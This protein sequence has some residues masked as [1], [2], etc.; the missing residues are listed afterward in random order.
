M[1][2]VVVRTA[3]WTVAWLL[4][5]GLGP[6]AVIGAQESPGTLAGVVLAADQPDQ[7]LRHAVVSLIDPTSPVHVTVVADDEGRFEFGDLRPGRYAVTASKPAYLTSAF[8][9]RRT[10]DA[11]T[12]IALA[13]GQRVE[14][15]RITLARGAVIAG[16]VRDAAGAPAANI[17]IVVAPAATTSGPGEYAPASEALTTDAG[18]AYRAFN[19][20]PGD[21]VIVAAIANVSGRGTIYRPTVAE[22]D[23]SLFALQQRVS[24]EPAASPQPLPPGPA[25]LRTYGWA[26]V[27]YP[28]TSSAAD[29]VRV[30]VDAGDVR[31]DLDFAIDLAPLLTVQGVVVGADGSPAPATKSIARVGPPLPI[32]AQS[33]TAARE[34]ALRRSTVAGVLVADA[35]NFTDV[36]PGLYVVTAR[37]FRGAWAA[38]NVRVTDSPIKDL[39]LVMQPPMSLSGRLVFDGSPNAPAANAASMRVGLAPLPLEPAIVRAAGS[40]AGP[41]IGLPPPPPVTAAADGTFSIGEILPGQF[42]IEVS[43][44][45]GAPGLGGWWLESAL[46]DG[47]DLLDQP[48]DFGG[49]LREINDVVLTLTDRR[50]ELT[51]RLQTADGQPMPDYHVIVFSPDRAHWFSGARRTRAVRPATDGVFSVA[52]LPAGAY[53]VAA[54]TDLPADDYQRAAFLEQLA[55]HAVRVAVRAGET[56]RQDLQIAG[57]N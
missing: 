45:T 6:A 54:L 49:A 39:R 14:D 56:T 47:R 11:G 57:G 48:L 1:Q 16:H 26:P 27:F 2:R 32:Y 37:A 33:S 51:G 24:G 36:T 30:R 40:G 25:V 19:L 21:Y 34:Q 10:G 4:A 7:P 31:E 43:G 41:V 29:A 5:V 46:A 55:P 3:W 38:T 9:A 13:A 22:I 8:G 18:G 35:L 28:G 17:S 52:E 53:L 50:T 15:L 42:A 23:A 12:P 44:V 20:P